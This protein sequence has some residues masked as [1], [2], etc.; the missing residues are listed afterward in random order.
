MLLVFLAGGL[1]PLLQTIGLFLWADRWRK[2][3]LAL[4]AF[5]G[6]F[7]SLYFAAIVLG[8]TRFKRFDVTNAGWLALSSL[9]GIVV[10][11]TWWLVA[12]ERLGA[13]RMI[14]VDAIKPF[15]ALAFGAALLGDRVPLVGI[16][17]VFATTAG[18]YLLNRDDAD[19]P[20]KDANAED[21]RNGGAASKETGDDAAAGDDALL[22]AARGASDGDALDGIDVRPGASK[23]AD[24]APAAAKQADRW[25]L[26]RL[27][28]GWSENS[29][30]EKSSKDAVGYAYAAANVVLDVYAATLTI[31]KHGAMSSA[32]INLV[33]FLFAGI[34]LAAALG[35]RSGARRVYAR[36]KVQMNAD[37]AMSRRDWAAVLV[38]IVFVTVLVPL[39]TVW[40]MLRLPLAFAVTLNSVGPIY[41]L[42]VAVCF[43]KPV[44]RTAVFGALLATGGVVLLS[45]AVFR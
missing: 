29:W 7:A 19:P 4:N 9:L 25:S 44:T 5:K 32:D 43:G 11:D 17:G 41:A 42:P 10:A 8:T 27:S 16:G 2:S 34:V 40:V 21:A 30:S 28:R 35:V 22:R 13:K 26:D 24:F 31:A 39:V 38:G 45:F 14:A 15:V 36:G 20:T 3:A 37:A 33:R 12:L 1:A 6:L 23:S 18:I